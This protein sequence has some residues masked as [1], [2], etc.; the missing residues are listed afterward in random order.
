MEQSNTIDRLQEKASDL[1][2]LEWH[3]GR[4]QI[5]SIEELKALKQAER[6]KVED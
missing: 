3:L 2:S 4:E 6:A 1:R 5:Q